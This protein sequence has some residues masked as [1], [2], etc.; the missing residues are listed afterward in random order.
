MGGSK[1]EPPCESGNAVVIPVCVG[2]L[3]KSPT[4]GRATVYAHNAHRMT[5]GTTVSGVAKVDVVFESIPTVVV[6]EYGCGLGP[7]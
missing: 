5:D 1:V 2:H 6:S 7:T 4:C 3:R